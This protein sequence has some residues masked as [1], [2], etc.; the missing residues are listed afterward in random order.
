[1]WFPRSAF[2]QTFTAI[3]L[4]WLL[5]GASPA[6][7]QAVIKVSDEVRFT[8]GV[9][10]QVQADWLE[11][12]EGD[13]TTQNLFIRRF[14]VLL[15]G[16]VAKNVTFFAETD[17]PNLGKTLPGGKNISP[18]M[19]VQ[20]AFGSF[21]AHDAFTLDAGL[22]FVPFSRNSIQAAPSLLPI[23]YGPFTFAQS[24]A[25][26]STTGR[27]TGFQARGY[28]LSQHL[29]YRAGAFQGAR[30]ERSN[31]SFRYVGRVQFEFLEPEGMGF[32]YTGTSLGKRKVLAVGAAFDTQNDYTAYDADA[33]LDYPLGPGA[34]TAQVAYNRF[35][36]D[37]TFVTLPKQDVV[38]VEL[39]YLLSSLK[40]TPVLQFSDRAIS[41]TDVG[42]EVRWSVGLNYWWAGH[43][44]NIKGAYTLIDPRGRP[45]QNEFT[46]Q[47]Q[48][49]YY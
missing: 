19:I 33:Y 6:S 12:P 47:F 26:Q 48:F 13:D 28:L 32:F 46:I 2:L 25:T 37:E 39:G 9:L 42:D 49:F 18:G 35:D 44:A 5:V 17:V 31:R 43:N 11:D 7:A 23:D 1:M 34:L 38:L 29:E 16:Q 22:M 27:D 24:A 3:A 45:E 21:K 14:R 4:A 40:L 30:D 41:D 15:G 36:G 10:G 8:L 20:D